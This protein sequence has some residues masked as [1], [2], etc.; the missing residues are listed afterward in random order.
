MRG[1]RLRFLLGVLV[2]AVGI[3]FALNLVLP[4]ENLYSIRLLDGEG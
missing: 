2:L 3:R 1:E 4:P